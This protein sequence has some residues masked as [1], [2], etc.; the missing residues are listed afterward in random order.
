MS[1]SSGDPGSGAAAEG[2]SWDYPEPHLVTVTAVRDDIDALGHVNNQVY[3]AWLERAAWSHSAAR[4]ADWHTYRRLDRAMVAR[5]HEIDYL[6][7]CYE[8]DTVLV[9]TWV[10]APTRAGLTRLYQGIRER[11]GRTV[12]RAR[13]RWACVS[14]STGRPARM[15]AEFVEAYRA[16]I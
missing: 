2:L 8:G 1:A 13:T 14:L 12:M 6:G 9:G 5:R 11:D 3:L 15:P 16:T 10:S 7:A 4:G